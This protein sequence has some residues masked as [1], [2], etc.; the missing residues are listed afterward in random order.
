MT[1]YPGSVVPLA[2]FTSFLALFPIPH[3]VW[4]CNGC[5]STPGYLVLFG[6]RSAMPVLSVVVSGWLW[7]PRYRQCSKKLSW[8]APETLAYSYTTWLLQ[9]LQMVI[10]IPIGPLEPLSWN[11]HGFPPPCFHVCVHKEFQRQ[12]ITHC[13]S[14]VK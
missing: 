6:F 3:H 10:H 8:T 14:G 11:R 2:M 13:V 4:W 1:Q 5:H 12:K 9:L 7:P